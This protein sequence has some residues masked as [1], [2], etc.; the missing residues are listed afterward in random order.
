[1][2]GRIIKTTGSWHWISDGDKTIRAR[3]PGSF[4][5]E[6]TK[7][8]NPVSAGDIVDYSEVGDGTALISKIHTRTNYLNRKGTGSKSHQNHV[9]A[10][11]IDFAWCV[12]SLHLPRFNPGFIDRFLVMATASDIEAGIILNKTDLD[13]KD[14]VRETVEDLI[15]IYRSLG[16]SVLETVATEEKGIE[17]LLE[18][19]KGKVSLLIG[20]SGVGKSSLLNAVIPGINAST[21]DISKKTRKGKHTTT[22]IELHP[23]PEGG[24]VIDSPGIKEYGI[25]DLDRV[26]LSHQ[27]VDMLPFIGECQYQDCIHDHEPGCAIKEAVENGAIREE[28]YESYLTILGSLDN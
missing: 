13:V 19:L 25:R 24:F 14:K 27:F 26:H 23:I 8:T 28:R 4:R 15:S 2:Q 1:M 12:Q 10:S 22:F 7:V 3:I 18:V 11:N 9:I 5:N 20:P 16:Y 21:G 17:P 6:Y